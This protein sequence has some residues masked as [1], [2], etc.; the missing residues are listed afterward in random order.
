MPKRPFDWE[1]E[2]GLTGLKRAFSLAPKAPKGPF[3][4][5]AGEPAVADDVRRGR[6]AAKG[7][8]RS[9]LRQPGLDQGFAETWVRVDP[10]RVVGVKPRQGEFWIH[11]VASASAAFASGILSTAA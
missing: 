9:L 7:W 10:G 11:F 5:S 2:I 1:R 3:L 4:V 8:A 6:I